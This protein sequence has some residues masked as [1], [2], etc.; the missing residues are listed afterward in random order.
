MKSL[1]ELFKPRL[2]ESFAAPPFATPEPAKT[3][4]LSRGPLD[5]FM[6]PDE[7]TLDD[8]GKL[9][10]RKLRKEMDERYTRYNSFNICALDDYMQALR[11]PFTPDT[12]ESYKKLHKLHCVKFDLVPPALYERSP[13][14]FNHVVSCGAVKHPL[15]QDQLV[16]DV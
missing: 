15:I 1:I 4:P 16:I 7:A 9:E 11:I 12:K 10:T 8:W 3:F 14:W 2:H 6:F 5:Q 13:H